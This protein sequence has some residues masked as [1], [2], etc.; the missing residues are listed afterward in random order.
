M[1][2][3]N[4]DVE[5]AVAQINEQIDGLTKIGLRRMIVLVGGYRI[6][7]SNADRSW[8]RYHYRIAPSY[9]DLLTFDANELFISGHTKATLEKALPL[10]KWH[11]LFWNS[12]EAQN[13]GGV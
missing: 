10:L 3:L 2:K 8:W 1:T 5:V 9:S 4:D 13:D 12:Y 11:P 7:W 6:A